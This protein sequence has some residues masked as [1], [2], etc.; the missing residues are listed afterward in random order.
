MREKG[1][2]N[3]IPALADGGCSGGDRTVLRDVGDRGDLGA[4]VVGGSLGT[5]G[6]RREVLWPDDRCFGSFFG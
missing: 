1:G 5:G 6:G 4:V 3:I 2:K